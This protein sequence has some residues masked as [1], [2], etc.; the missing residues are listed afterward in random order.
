MGELLRKYK[1]V[2]LAIIVMLLMLCTCSSLFVLM[3]AIP[4]NEPPSTKSI[5]DKTRALVAEAETPQ[6]GTITEP[7]PQPEATPEPEPP[8]DV[9]PELEVLAPGEGNT[10]ADAM[11]NAVQPIIGENLDYND[12]DEL[13]VRA[14]DAGHAHP[15]WALPPGVGMDHDFE[16]GV[17]TFWHDLAD[18]SRITFYA[19]PSGAVS[20]D[21]AEGGEGLTLTGVEINR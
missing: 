19:E 21:S 6:A 2:L 5:G 13:L 16:T 15:E 9:T 10:Y 3:W 11:Y 14:I 18:G 8:A 20:W 1:W 17:R 7:E 12:G 4:A